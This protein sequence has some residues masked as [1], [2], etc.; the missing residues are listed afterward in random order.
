LVPGFFSLAIMRPGR[1]ADHSSPS[2]TEEKNAWSYTPNMPSWH[3]AQLKEQGQ[4][5]P[6]LFTPILLKFSF[7]ISCF[8]F[9]L[10]SIFLSF[11]LCCPSLFLTFSFCSLPLLLSFN[12]SSCQSPA[13]DMKKL[14]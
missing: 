14:T 13:V 9:F 6:L 8:L 3:G 7:V 10:I 4:I 12:F 11:V 1:E 5:L 2:S